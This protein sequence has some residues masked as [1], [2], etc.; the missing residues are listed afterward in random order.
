MKITNEQLK[1]IIKE[2][3]EAVINE[4]ED[5]LSKASRLTGGNQKA[6]KALKYLNNKQYTFIDIYDESPTLII[7]DDKG[8]AYFANNSKDEPE[9]TKEI[10]LKQLKPAG[11]EGVGIIGPNSELR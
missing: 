5:E 3:I 6:N 2:E 1:Q 9:K 11:Y 8:E 7:K 4:G 10:I